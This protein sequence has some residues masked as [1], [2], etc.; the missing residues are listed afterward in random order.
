M[1][2][3]TQ[4]ASDSDMETALEEFKQRQGRRNS[5]GSAKYA[6]SMPKCEAT[7][8]RLDQ[9]DRHEYHHT[10]IVSIVNC[11]LSVSQ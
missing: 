3:G 7:F 8:K 2:P 5:I 10:G 1:P 6:C 9:L 4:I 11:M